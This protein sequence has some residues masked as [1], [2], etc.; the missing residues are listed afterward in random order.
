MVYIIKQHTLD[1]AAELGLIVHPS[2]NPKYKLEIYDGT[3]GHFLYYG[4]D[5]Q[6]SDYP[7]YL[8]THS[9]AFAD[10]RRRLYHAR[11]QKEIND[12]GSRGS[13]IAYLLW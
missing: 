11:H 4:G 6:Y 12:V 5:T 2:D 8:E 1:R 13:V 10:T 9:K 7:S 3:T